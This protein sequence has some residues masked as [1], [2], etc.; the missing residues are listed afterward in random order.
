MGENSLRMGFGART[1]NSLLHHIYPQKT[2]FLLAKLEN[3]V[4]KAQVQYRATRVTK[5]SSV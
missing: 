1:L 2:H 3:N 4:Q 5:I